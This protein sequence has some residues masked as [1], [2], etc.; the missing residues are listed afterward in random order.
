MLRIRTAL[1]VGVCALGTLIPAAGA[2]AVGFFPTLAA[3]FTQELYAADLP[4]AVGIAFARDGDVFTGFDAYTPLRRVD[5]QTTIVEHG[6]AVHPHAA[7]SP[8]NNYYYLGLTNAQNGNVYS[9]TGNGA[10]EIDATTGQ[11]IGTPIPGP[12]AGNG[13][14]I[15]VDP[16]TG[17]IV[18]ATNSGIAWVAPDGSGS[19]WFSTG[20]ADGITFDP[21]GNYLF[22]AIG[23][24]VDVINRAGTHVQSIPLTTPA[25]YGADGVA[26]HAGTP[27]FVVSVNNSGDITRFDFPGG[28]YT[29]PP[30]QSVFASGGFRGDLTQVGAD[31]CLYLSQGGTRFADGTVVTGADPATEGS[32]VKICPGFVPPV[33][34]P[35][36][37]VAH[38]YLL[39]GGGLTLT[40]S[41]TLTANGNPVAGE[42]VTFK[43]GSRTICTA[44]T[45][46]AG[47]A[48]CSVPLAGLLPVLLSG[49]YD[50][51][52]AGNGAL[53]PSSDHAGVL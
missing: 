15:T 13:L 28:D 2:Q 43:A 21:T 40:P 16:Q 36:T 18:Y 4:Y 20:Y 32:I 45:N 17:H 9:N 35:T 6:S 5:A 50:A 46:A 25:S 22:A 29:Q 39:G 30:T 47:V 7:V 11:P 19:G 12:G 49:G 23:G 51:T 1:L 31:G 34:T 53:E 14:G 10:E 8:A 33:S 41:A 38:P 44:T 52:Y 27:N 37:L 48:K 3:P 26:F 42:P 24:G